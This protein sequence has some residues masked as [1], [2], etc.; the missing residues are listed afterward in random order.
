MRTKSKMLMALGLLL[1]MLAV[2]GLYL[3]GG[4]RAQT[5]VDTGTVL[6][7]AQ[8][9]SRYTQIDDQNARAL[10]VERSVP[11]DAIPSSAVRS[12]AELTPGLVVQTL[13]Y[14]GEFLLK[15]KLS[16][17]Q[18]QTTSLAADRRMKDG[19]VAMAFTLSELGVVAGGVQPNDVVDILVTY[20]PTSKGMV[21]AAEAPPAK[22]TWM[23]LQRVLV[24]NVG[25]NY[26]PNPEVPRPAEAPANRLTTVTL[27]LTP[28]E[29]T[30]LKFLRDDG[31]TFDFV[32]HRAG[33]QTDFGQPRVSAED[34]VQL[35]LR[36]E[37]W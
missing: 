22:V 5:S 35:Y 4:V 27:L 18:Q 13:L 37:G 24:L 30:M 34:V 26:V 11:R 16:I 17:G 6:V 23:L 2:G 7:A 10:F 15:E 14:P 31:A 8:K 29:A 36:G 9:V 3:Y 28:E 20:A 32:L 33:D 19:M 12:F 21:A 1:A 25:T